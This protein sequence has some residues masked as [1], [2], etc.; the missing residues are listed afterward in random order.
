MTSIEQNKN[1]IDNVIPNAILRIR[2]TFNKSISCWK[3]W[4]IHQ[5]TA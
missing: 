5:M 4:G 1:S 3:H 2:S